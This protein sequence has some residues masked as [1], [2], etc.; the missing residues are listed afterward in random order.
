MKFSIGAFLLMTIILLE[1]AYCDIHIYNISILTL[2]APVWWFKCILTLTSFCLIIDVPLSHLTYIFLFHLL[3]LVIFYSG[4]LCPGLVLVG[5]LAEALV[6]I[7][8]PSAW[9]TAHARWFC[10][11]SW[12]LISLWSLPPPARM[13]SRWFLFPAQ[14]Y[15]FF[16]CSDGP[17]VLCGC[18]HICFSINLLLYKVSGLWSAEKSSLLRA[19]EGRFASISILSM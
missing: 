11:C 16:S 3:P 2:T 17:C 19:C 10:L 14:M 8:M 15:M 1:Y 13:L 18:A 6:A 9:R 12:L 5:W 4:V 7:E